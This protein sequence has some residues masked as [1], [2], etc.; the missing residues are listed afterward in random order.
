MAI[1]KALDRVRDATAGT[2][3]RLMAAG[4]TRAARVARLK[5]AAPGRAVPLLGA[6]AAMWTL[7]EAC[8][9]HRGVA[10]DR[11]GIDGQVCETYPRA[12]L[13]AWDQKRGQAQL[14]RAA[15]PLPFPDRC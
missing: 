15:A 8:L 1:S 5:L 6:T 9:A 12:V 4:H 13:A 3:G 14:D 7:I 10:V 11:S 2:V